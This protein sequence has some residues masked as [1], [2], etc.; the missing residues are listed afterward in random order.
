MV[1]G[2]VGVYEVG[3]GRKFELEFGYDY[4]YLF[5]LG[6]LGMCN[7]FFCIFC[8]YFNVGNKRDFF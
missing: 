1:V 6:F 8:F 2:D 4:R 5:M 3:R 7:D